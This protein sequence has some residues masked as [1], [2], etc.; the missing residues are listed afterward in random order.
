MKSYP[1]PRRMQSGRAIFTIPTVIGVISFV[2]LI[3]ALTGDGVRD[4]ISW[5]ALL[6]PVATIVWAMHTRRS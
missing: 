3:S 4:V 1:A 6:I 2:G 5:V